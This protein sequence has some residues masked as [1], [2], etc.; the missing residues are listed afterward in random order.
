MAATDE[1]RLFVRIEAMMRGFQKDMQ[2]IVKTGGDAATKVE[3]KFK[4]S[5]E[6]VATS[7]GQTKAAAANLSFQM[8]DIAQGLASG[9]SPFTL[10]VQQGSQVAQALQQAGDEAGSFKN[11][12]VSAFKSMLS[13]QSL[14]AFSLIGLTAYAVKYFSSVDEGASKT[15]KKLKEHADAIGGIA[16]E[17]KDRLPESVRDTIDEFERLTKITTQIDQMKA[18][19]A[20]VA[21]EVGDKLGNQLVKVTGLA[22]ELLDRRIAVPVE[23]DGQQIDAVTALGDAWTVVQTEVEAGRHPTEAIVDLLKILDAIELRAPGLGAAE[24]A[25][26]LRTQVS[27]EL[28]KSL[29]WTEA[30]NTVM[31]AVNGQAQTLTGRVRELVAQFLELNRLLT[32]PGLPDPFMP[33]LTTL[34]TLLGLIPKDFSFFGAFNQGVARLPGVHAEAVTAT[35]DTARTFL[36][37]KAQNEQIAASLVNL[38]DETAKAMA[39][40]FTLLPETARITSGVRSYEEQERLYRRYKSGE[41]GL[42]APPGTSRHEFGRAVDI[43]AGVDMET[44]REAVRL[45]P[46]LE[47]L[48]GRAYEIDKVHVQM[49]GTAAAVE[50]QR[51]DD[52][53]AG[54]E[55]LAD[56]R[57]KAAEKQKKAQEN[58]TDYLAT[59]DEQAALQVRINEINTN[60]ALNA[61]QKA[62][63]I[64]VETELQKALNQ[65]KRDNLTLSEAE[66]AMVRRLAAE[67]AMAKIAGDAI[68][69]A[70]KDAAKQRA[71]ALKE[72]QKT[73]EELENTMK[74]ALG[75]LVKDLIAGKDA[76][77]A[78]SDAL[79]KVADKLLDIGLDMLLGGLFGGGG[80]GGGLGGIFK[81]FLGRQ[82]GG[83]VN[84]R[85]PYVV[86]ETRP[87]LFVP[88]S[89]GRIQPQVPSLR[90]AR[91]SHDVANVRIMA[92]PGTIA[93]IADQ[94]IKTASGTIVRVSVVESQKATRRNFGSM[95]GEAQTRQL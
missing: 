75:G 36:Q 30:V 50:K 45:V 11:T 19:I 80:S 25:K 69:Q 33:M 84:A 73:A 81:A 88:Q 38:T 56:E 62:I 78:L 35:G 48:K 63:A 77:E 34:E 64:E 23:I 22:I 46:E 82:S 90:A 10:M 89:A 86:G 55:K 66:I 87:E 74:D 6:N 93:D 31:G 72:T 85:Q 4:A 41:G 51:V 37:T 32:A 54:E 12:V 79:G 94:R 47:Q 52:M 18:A 71:D 20:A 91:S 28:E 16:D 21:T 15:N 49:A 59:L 39:K 42:A 8:N 65:A 92:D 17:Y 44:L 61:D 58:L 26:M 43:G 7:F 57:E 13:W 70:E 1:A 24:L 3:K 27:P 68:A 53:I 29:K 14:V 83:P 2:T 95:L 67:K 40:L 60:S 9:T 5:N 76:S